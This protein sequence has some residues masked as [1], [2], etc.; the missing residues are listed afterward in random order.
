MSSEQPPLER[1][2]SAVLASTRY[3]EISSELVRNIGAQELAKRRNLK[4]A[5]KAS[6]N[7]LHQ[8]SGAYLAR[9]ENYTA[10][11]DELST[12]AQ[13]ADQDAIQQVCKKIMSYHIST[14]ER[15]P[16]LNEF[17]STILS[18]L[19]PISSVLD[20][21]CGLNPLAM[22]WM[23]LQ[24]DTIYYACDI[25]QPMINFLNRYMP[26]MGIKGN[27]ELCD[28]IQSCP[29]HEV[30]VAFVLKTIPCLEQVN[31]QAG[32]HLLRNIN[33]KHMIVSFPVHSLG[34]CSKGM[35]MH[36]E[37]HFRQLVGD[38]MWEI[39]RIEFATEL[40]FVVGK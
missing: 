26:L 14:R 39:S 35:A 9:Q 21:A 29:T 36:Y 25:Y 32:Y 11:F 10:C 7:K 5:I 22:P 12:V 8:V 23:P 13:S 38:E 19:T 16:I 2:V 34:G 20:I 27:A 30:D 1:L 37:T 3:R 33:A 24:E 18:D 17:Y 4:E 31:K 28:V 6:K 40:V 15:L